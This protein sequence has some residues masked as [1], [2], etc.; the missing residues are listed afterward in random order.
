MTI[1]STVLP[2]VV[3]HILSAVVGSGTFTTEAQDAVSGTVHDSQTE[4]VV[5][6]WQGELQIAGQKLK[7]QLRLVNTNGKTLA[8][9]D[10]ISQ[11]VMGLAATMVPHDS[12]LRFEV[13]R[14]MGRFEGKLDPARKVATGTWTQAGQGM[15]LVLSKTDEV[16][17]ELPKSQRPQTPQP[18]FAYQS[19]D[20][21]F[22]NSA[23]GIQLAGTLVIPAGD[24]PFPAVVLVS[25]S[26]PQDRDEEI[27]Q[28]RPFLVIADY[29]ARHGIA[30]LR[31]DDRG[32][33]KST[34]DFAAATT[35]DFASDTRAALAYLRDRQGVD[36]KRLGI[37]GHSEGGMIAAMLAA[38]ESD[39]SHVVL[40]AGPGVPG[41]EILV[42]QTEALVKVSG[43]EGDA[44]NAQVSGIR[45]ITK[46]IKEGAPR[47]EVDELIQ[48]LVSAQ[49]PEDESQEARKQ[50]RSVLTSQLKQFATPWFEYFIRYDPRDDLR[51]ARCPVLAMIGELDLQVLSSLNLPEIETAL[52]AAGVDHRCEK[53]P[54]LN[55]LFQ[56]AETG[57]IDEYFQIEETISPEALAMIEEWVRAH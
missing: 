2:V 13:P 23:A 54:R 38:T 56:T 20:V 49:L 46:K 40:L 31:Y 1:R 26:G 19:E 48:E 42:S 21:K 18:P 43:L 55:H 29:L 12:E 33:H 50:T 24:G 37:V 32:T 15:P 14:V 27:F 57:S 35:A 45:D 7:L 16:I 30:S 17:H 5:E 34:G 41:D 4:K 10:S 39:L 51:R 44:L 6:A 52:Q 53:L 11:G 36:R 8:M 47:E 25:G 22:E 3:W 28:H 9:F